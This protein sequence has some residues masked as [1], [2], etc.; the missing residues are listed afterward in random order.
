MGFKGVEK[1][2]DGCLRDVS[3]VFHE[4]FKGA[5]RK[6]GRWSVRRGRKRICWRLRCL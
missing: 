3:K 6:I 2:F 1:N 5:S 4:S